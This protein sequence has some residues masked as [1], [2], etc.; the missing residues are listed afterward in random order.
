MVCQ[1]GVLLL[2]GLP[3]Q[4]VGRAET[5]TRGK[6]FAVQKNKDRLLQIKMT[7]EKFNAKNIKPVQAELPED[8]GELP[9]PDIDFSLNVKCSAFTARPCR[10]FFNDLVIALFVDRVPVQDHPI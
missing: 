1:D 5:A 4:L 8:F 10:A 9:A 2:D 3:E 7:I 6:I